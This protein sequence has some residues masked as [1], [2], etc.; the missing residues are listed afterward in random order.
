M[1]LS[2]F[3][4]RRERIVNVNNR[5][6]LSRLLGCKPQP[7]E[8]ARIA[9]FKASLKPFEEAIERAKAKHGRTAEI[10]TAQREFVNDLLRRGA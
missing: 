4:S 1:T 7:T 2:F 6:W 8:A 10:L 3:G 5:G 9:A